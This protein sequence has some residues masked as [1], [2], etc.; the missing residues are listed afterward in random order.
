MKTE[1]S[2]NDFEHDYIIECLS[3]FVSDLKTG[4]PYHEIV[5]SKAVQITSFMQGQIAAGIK[6]RP[7][8]T[9]CPSAT[10]LEVLKQL[11][12]EAGL[13]EV[14]GVLQLIKEGKW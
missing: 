8:Q 13:D 4:K 3:H 7:Q 11:V 2:P 12:S 6:A 10:I 9:I 5:D 14:E 1:F